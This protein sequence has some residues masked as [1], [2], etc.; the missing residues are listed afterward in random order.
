M[1]DKKKTRS[2]SE[3]TQI[4][5]L[6]VDIADGLAVTNQN[7]VVLKAQIDS[8]EPEIREGV[9]LGKRAVAIAQDVQSKTNA[10]HHLL[11]DESNG[12]GARI[13]D[14]EQKNGK[15]AKARPSRPPRRG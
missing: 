8:L 11:I 7:L 1:S 9:R 5:K 4:R 10:L 12:L 13:Y 15:G 3:E 14:L 2:A 6:L